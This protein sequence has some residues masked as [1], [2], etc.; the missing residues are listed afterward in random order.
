M[1][2]KQIDR[3]ELKR[4]G[5]ISS[6]SGSSGIIYSDGFVYIIA[7]KSN[8]LSVFDVND[9]TLKKEISLKADGS[10][11][12]N[13]EKKYKP[14]FEAFSRHGNRYFI[15]GS[16]SA[17][18]RFDLVILDERFDFVERLSIE[19]LYL[20]M[21]E[22]T[23]IDRDNF[24]I[25]GVILEKD[26]ALFFN[27]GNGPDRKNGIVKVRN[28]LTDEPEVAGYSSIVLPDINGRHAA[29][30]DAI[31]HDGCIC[32][33][34]NGED[35]Q[36]VYD[37]GA[38]AGSAFGMMDLSTFELLEFHIIDHSMK[39]EGLAVYKDLKEEHKMVF[40]VCDDNDFEDQTII[41]QLTV[42]WRD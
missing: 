8:V 35:T 15:F 17:K 19:N 33:L 41:S 38:V 18:N 22:S 27:R 36:S 40:I 24:N 37:D 5:F 42:F 29:F 39:L 21:M 34:A 14:D 4:R 9:Q 25:E 30:S 12:A 32:F 6:F 7:D 11:E 28:W 20:A 10:L 23:G 13:V 2:V 26:F 31:L 16:G 1:K 3:V